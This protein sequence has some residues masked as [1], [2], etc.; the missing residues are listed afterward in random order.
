MLR[1]VYLDSLENNLKY[2]PEFCPA[3][4][5]STVEEDQQILGVGSVESFANIRLSH[6]FGF[7]VQT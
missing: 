2:H 6:R 5:N 7:I 4:H 1:D 3:F